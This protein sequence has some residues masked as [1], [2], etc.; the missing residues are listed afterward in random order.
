MSERYI[1]E[2]VNSNYIAEQARIDYN[3]NLVVESGYSPT[4]FSSLEIALLYK[5]LL[6]MKYPGKNFTIKKT[7]GGYYTADESSFNGIY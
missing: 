6:E 7:Y 3:L 1:I 2:S 5:N 4:A